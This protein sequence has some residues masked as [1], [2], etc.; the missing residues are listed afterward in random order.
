MA[1]Q[2]PTPAVQKPS[3]T[4]TIPIQSEIDEQE[5]SIDLMRAFL[6]QRW[7]GV[8]PKYIDERIAFIIERNVIFPGMFDI[9][10]CKIT[11]IRRFF[12]IFPHF[13]PNIPWNLLK[14]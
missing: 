13:L 5:E 12:P 4:V 9:F 6:M 7:D 8:E 2:E 10:W 3:I 14:I 11:K 1:P